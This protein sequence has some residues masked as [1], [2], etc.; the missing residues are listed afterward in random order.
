MRTRTGF[1][2]NSSSTSFIVYLPDS[3]STATLDVSGI[4]EEG[5]EDEMREM[6]AQM[7]KG[8]SYYEADNY[9]IFEFLSE[10][11]EEY[12]IARVDT[13]SDQ[14]QIVFLGADAKE[15]IKEIIKAGDEA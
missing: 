4:A 10:A 13:S 9:D 15:H 14:G 12:I 7:I 3:F 8:G 6:I 1:V 5:K 11:V 2:S